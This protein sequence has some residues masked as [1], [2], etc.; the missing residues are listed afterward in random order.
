MKGSGQNSS[1]EWK[2]A[3]LRP[4][5]VPKDL[6]R[7]VA[8]AGGAD[9]TGADLRTEIQKRAGLGALLDSPDYQLVRIQREWPRLAGPLGNISY[10][11]RLKEQGA[12]LEVLV[13]NPVH[14]QELQ[15]YQHEILKNMKSAGHSVR[16]LYI[17]ND[18][19]PWDRIRT[20]AAR[21]AQNSTPPGGR[22]RTPSSGPAASAAGSPAAPEEHPGLDE[23]LAGLRRPPNT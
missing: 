20:A 22:A 7:R 1:G 14:G 15:L 17:R 21:D 4:R 16:R 8:A 3:D 13:E 12:V 9:A 19:I 11:R 18:R 23:L 2:A 10:P 6:G 5:R